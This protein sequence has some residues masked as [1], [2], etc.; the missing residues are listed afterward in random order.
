MPELCQNCGAEL[1]GGQQ[2]CRRCGTPV[3]AGAP[4]GEAPTQLFPE[5]AQPAPAPE[6]DARRVGVETGPFGGQQPTAYY[7]P[8]SHQRTSPL[9]GQPFDS[10]PLAVEP[11]AP[12]RRRRGAWLFALLAVF[13]LG[14]G[15]ASGAAYLWWRAT[16]QPIVVKKINT[17]A[18]GVPEVPPVPEIPEIPADL[19]DRIKEAL[20]TAGVPLP[21]DETGAVVSGDTTTLTRTYELDGGSSFG[22]HLIKGDVSVTG[23]DVESVVVK[24]V[25]RGGS[26]AERGAARVLESRTDE[27]LTLLTAPGAPAVNV[28]YEVTVPRELRRLEI[29]AQQ[30]DV[31]VSGFAGAIVADVR[32]GD[33]EFRDVSGEVRSKVIKG[34]T[35]V[36]QGGA[37]RE[38]SQQFSVV[39]GDIEATFADGAG[40][41]LK[42][43][44]L[45]GDI[46]GTD[47]FGLRVERAPAGRHVAG[48]LGEGGEA[49]L[50][51]V[52][53]GDI[54][55]KK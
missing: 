20:K 2:F 13:V 24:I 10:R 18:A 55:L 19:G 22:V 14:A 53:N 48:R 38:G 43:E 42:A 44:T 40:A 51:K 47:A 50:F 3:S 8:A 23:A 32:T 45:D 28:S 15:L 39:R 37:E 36:F 7:P 49:L 16:R 1:Y 9:V 4:G 6:A 34:D 52:T 30:G 54:R 12:P 31:R 41:D 27:G 26:A 25:K 17:T 11:P 33:V 35:R 5:G 46:E 21:V 29:E